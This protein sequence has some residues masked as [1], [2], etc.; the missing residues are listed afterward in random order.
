MS[1]E[2][3]WVLCKIS[4]VDFESRQFVRESLFEIKDY[5]KSSYKVQLAF[6]IAYGNPKLEDVYKWQNESLKY[7]DLIITGKIWNIF[8]VEWVDTSYNSS[9]DCISYS[10]QHINES[11]LL[12]TYVMNEFLAASC[13]RKTKY[14]WKTLNKDL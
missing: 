6:V 3:Q 12:H 11:K 5:L 1:T 2:A 10:W 13:S 8:T 4:C 7:N 9:S 14:F